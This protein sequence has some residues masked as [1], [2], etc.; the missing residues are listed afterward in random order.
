VVPLR[1][2]SCSDTAKPSLRRHQLIR[3]PPA[4]HE[5][6][7]RGDVRSARRSWEK[8][9]EAKA[10]AR[11]YPADDGFVGFNAEAVRDATT[12]GEVARG[13]SK[14]MPV[15]QARRMVN[16]LRES[17]YPQR[18]PVRDDDARSG[19]VNSPRGACLAAADT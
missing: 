11:G 1:P 2:W 19:L 18:V 8:R 17:K 10:K 16:E 9:Q 3:F 14:A 4:L 7:E 6:I 15:S 13:L 5:A 12:V